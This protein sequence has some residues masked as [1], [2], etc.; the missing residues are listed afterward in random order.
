MPGADG[1]QDRP[2]GGNWVHESLSTSWGRYFPSVRPREWDNYDYPCP[3]TDEFWRLY[4]EPIDTFLRYAALLDQAVQFLTPTVKFKDELEQQEARLH[5]DTLLAPAAQIASRGA[6]G[7]LEQRWRFPSLISAFMEM[8]F[9]D[10]L[11]GKYRLQCGACHAPFVSDA[12]QARYCSEQCR[13]R[14]QKRNLRAQIS[15]AKEMAKGG[16][17]PQDIALAMGKPVASIRGWLKHW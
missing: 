15:Q 16:S 5:F 14:Q 1:F 3:L 13:Y 2:T 17:R 8:A 6:D 4:A 7:S 12:Y 9:Q 11:A 10:A